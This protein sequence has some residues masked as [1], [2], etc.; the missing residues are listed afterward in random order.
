MSEQREAAGALGGGGGARAACG[1]LEVAEGK[2]LV[3]RVARSGAA[4]E[5]AVSRGGAREGVGN[6]RDLCARCR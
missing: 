1:E 6:M 5:Q 3:E 2:G 4:S